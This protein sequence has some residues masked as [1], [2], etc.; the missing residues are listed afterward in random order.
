MKTIDTIKNNFNKRGFVFDFF[1]TCDEAV[2]HI[3]S[4]IPE[5]SS[6]GFGGS[7][8][9]SESGLLSAMQQ[10][11]YDLIHRQL[12][13]DIPYDQIYKRMYLCDWYISSSNAL[14]EEGEV[15]NIDGRGNRVSAILDGPKN[16]ILLCGINKIVPD[17]PS[18]IDRTR[19]IASPKNCVRLN[20]KTPCAITGKC[21][22][23]NSPD[24]ICRATVILHHPTSGSN[25]YIIVVDK[26]LGY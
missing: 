8:T 23:C 5:G 26:E 13:T 3:L 21:E 22:N 18:A 17:L 7:V 15:I 10:K 16:V 6:I 9:V 12:R 4:L 24:T 14:T 1:S 25:V 19:N 11:N 2:N 20:K